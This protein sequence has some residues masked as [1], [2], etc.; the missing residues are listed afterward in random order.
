[1]WSP[2]IM[3]RLLYIGIITPFGCVSCM[4]ASVGILVA[5]NVDPIDDWVVSPT[6]YL[7]LL[8]TALRILARVAF[9]EGIKN[10]R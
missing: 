6:V 8:T 3:H 5:S 4:G 7:A 2:G 1:M 9:S 10:S